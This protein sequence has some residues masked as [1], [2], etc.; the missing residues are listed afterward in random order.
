MGLGIGTVLIV[1]V[2]AGN[3]VGDTARKGGEGVS[4]KKE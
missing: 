2:A 1:G 4:G 3:A